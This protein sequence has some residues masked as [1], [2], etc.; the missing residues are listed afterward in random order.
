MVQVAK[1]EEKGSD[2][3]L[4]SHLVR[5]AMLD[6]FYE[7]FVIS[8]DT[9]LIESI[10]IV[11][12]EV[13]KRVGLVAPRRSRGSEAPIPSPSLRAV[14]SFVVYVDDVDLKGFLGKARPRIIQALLDPPLQQLFPQ[15]RVF[16]EVVGFPQHNEHGL[17]GI[18][19]SPLPYQA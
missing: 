6:R 11:T 9:D 7:A 18:K 5:D 10:R 8:N 19:E 13:G 4:A 17:P 3:N 12:Q 15:I 1:V 16:L 14:G 2:A